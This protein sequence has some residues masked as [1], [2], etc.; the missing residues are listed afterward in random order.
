MRQRNNAAVQMSTEARMQAGRFTMGRSQRS[1]IVI[2][3]LGEDPDMMNS[4]AQA[5]G[6]V[7]HRN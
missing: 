7:Q 5:Q 4:V 6:W 2:P 1:V 3:Y